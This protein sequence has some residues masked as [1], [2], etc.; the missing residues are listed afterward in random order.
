MSKC[1]ECSEEIK[2]ETETHYLIE[3][4][5]DNNHDM[6][7][8]YCKNCKNKAENFYIRV[9]SKKEAKSYKVN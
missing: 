8:R 4:E 2:V 6:I 1:V 5:A 3:V 9:L 7:L